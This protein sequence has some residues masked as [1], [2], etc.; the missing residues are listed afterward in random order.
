MIEHETSL[1]MTGPMLL[2]NQ[3]RFPVLRLGGNFR[4]EDTSQCGVG[5]IVGHGPIVALSYACEILRRGILR[6]GTV[7]P[8]RL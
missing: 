6:I 4:F 5:L 3:V 1:V 8:G 2:D 7:H